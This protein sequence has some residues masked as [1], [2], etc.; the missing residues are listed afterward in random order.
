[1]FYKLV[2]VVGLVSVFVSGDQIFVRI[3]DNLDPVESC[4][5]TKLTLT[6]SFG[7][8]FYFESNLHT[9]VLSVL[10]FVG[11]LLYFLFG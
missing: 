7:L 5:E 3:D 1:M 9:S 4:N 11:I 6:V 2:I 10:Q 8:K